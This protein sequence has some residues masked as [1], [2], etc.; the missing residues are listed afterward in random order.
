AIPDAPLGG[1]PVLSRPA[2]RSGTTCQQLNAMP[3]QATAPGLLS[4][5][6]LTCVPSCATRARGA[7]RTTLAGP[8]GSALP[9]K[10]GSV[11]LLGPMYSAYCRF[12]LQS[13]LLGS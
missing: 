6:A 4:L 11:Y 8:S 13:G 7:L 12:F 5:R 3:C 10:T 1:G 2:H 9:L